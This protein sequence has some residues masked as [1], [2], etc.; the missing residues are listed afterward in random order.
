MS[1]SKA[2]LSKQADIERAANEMGV[3][4]EQLAKAL[5]WKESHPSKYG[6]KQ[7]KPTADLEPKPEN[8]E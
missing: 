5:E 6:R 4:A 8:S 3:D 7:K 1:K 2:K